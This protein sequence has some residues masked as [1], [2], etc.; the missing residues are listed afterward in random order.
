MFIFFL[1][2]RFN[3]APV[4]VCA[5]D[6]VQL[7]HLLAHIGSIPKGNSSNINSFYD[8]MCC[9]LQRRGKKTSFIYIIE[10]DLHERALCVSRKA[11]DIN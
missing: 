7:F 11:K 4:F 3:I 2:F 1:L 8:R 10:C 5:S 6:F 9:K